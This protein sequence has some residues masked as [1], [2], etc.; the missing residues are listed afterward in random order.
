MAPK[1]KITQR[2]PVLRD[3]MRQTGRAPTLQELCELFDV[4]SKNTASLMARRFVEAGGTEQN[5]E[6]TPLCTHQ[7]G[8][9]PETSRQRDRRIPLPRRGVATGY[10][11]P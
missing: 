5:R 8:T 10:H 7:E 2:I 11:E 1:S 3:Y 9:A 6:R 4:K